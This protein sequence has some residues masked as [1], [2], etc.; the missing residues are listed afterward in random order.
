MANIINGKIW[1]K[2]LGEN[3]YLAYGKVALCGRHLSCRRGGIM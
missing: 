1:I 2:F 3:T